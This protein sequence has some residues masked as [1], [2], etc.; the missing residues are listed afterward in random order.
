[1]LEKYMER[2]IMDSM[3]ID[4]ARGKKQMKN[5]GIILE[6]GAMRSVFEAGVL[7]RFMEEKVEIPNVLAVSAGAYAGMNYVS[8]QK[9]RLIDAVI[10]PLEKEKY[11]GAG[12]FFRK[13]TFFDMDYLFDEVPKTQ[14][15]FDFETFQK[16]AIRFLINTTDCDTGECVY[17]EEFESE[18][19]FWKLCKAA[20][21]LPFISKITHMDGQALLDGGVAD[22]IPIMKAIEEGWEKIIVV[23]TRKSNYRKKYRHLY[24]LLMRIIYR[25]YPELIQTVAKRADKYNASLEKVMELEEE[26]KALV[27]RPTEMSVNNQESDVETLM[28]YYYHGY[29]QAKERMGEIKEFLFA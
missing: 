24:M 26:G 6:G 17:H 23:L 19:Q 28:K 22:A 3:T 21:S 16:S 14:A 29:D 4:K 20:N 27:I 25:D 7:D 5:V 8:G 13:G 11:M 9:G 10:K 18:E 1:M 2:S 12:T 15:P